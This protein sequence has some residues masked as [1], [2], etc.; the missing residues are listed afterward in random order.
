MAAKVPEMLIA[1]SFSKNF[2]IYRERCG[3][4]TTISATTEQALTTMQAMQTVIRSNYSMPPSHG[5]RIVT[6]VFDDD[7]LKEDW[8]AELTQMR[9]R[10]ANVR[11]EL[12]KKL[13]ERQVTQDLSFITNQ[14]G[15]FSY[16][17]FT[18]DMVGRLR[19]EFGIYTAGNGRINVAGICSDNIDAVAEGFAAVLQRAK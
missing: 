18:P 5:A 19:E 6:T 12:R 8:E 13:E 3:G 7:E 14:N 11:V 17:G 15:M 2:G 9:E 4:L 1:S 10:I 16:T